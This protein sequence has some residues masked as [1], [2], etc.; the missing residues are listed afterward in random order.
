MKKVF[1]SGSISIKEIPQK[2]YPRLD[3]MIKNNLKI[4]VGDA[5]GIDSA[6]QNYFKSKGYSN[7]CVYSIYENA[8]Y[9]ADKNC[10]FKQIIF[11]HKIEIE[12]EG[13]EDKQEKE[14]KKERDKQ[15]FKDKAM[16]DECDYGLV[17]W[18]EKS[19]G[20]YQNIQNLARLKKFYEVYDNNINVMDFLNDK[21]KLPENIKILYEENNGLSAKELLKRLDNSAL[22][23]TKHLNKFLCENGIIKKIDGGYKALSGYESYIKVKKY[24]GRETKHI[25]YAVDLVNV[26]E[27]LISKEPSLVC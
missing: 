13:C 9:M 7:L 2:V 25:K 26:I 18:D 4:L 21:D 16:A 23:N 10:L 15:S 22:I 12:C 19:N 5:P 1:I 14:I 8:R 27:G 20:C 17:I 24:K 11:P 6:V 3:N